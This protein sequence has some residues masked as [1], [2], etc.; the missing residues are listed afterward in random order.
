VTVQRFLGCLTFQEQWCDRH[1]SV[2]EVRSKI[3]MKHEGAAKRERAIAYALSHQVHVVAHLCLAVV[4][5]GNTT[6]IVSF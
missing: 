4:T 1:G 2:D 6:S 5:L 3:H